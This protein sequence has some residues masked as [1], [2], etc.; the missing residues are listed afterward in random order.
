MATGVS[1]TPVRPAR[2]SG[3]RARTVARVVRSEAARGSAVLTGA[4]ATVGL[5]Y[6]VFVYDV[7]WCGT[8]LGLGV[9]LRSS[10]DIAGAVVVAGATWAAGRERR[11]GMGELFGSTSRPLWHRVVLEWAAVTLV[12]TVGLAAVWAAGAVLTGP[13][14]SYDGGRVW[15]PLVAVV[16]V[17][18]LAAVGIAIGRL[19]P[20]RGAA[21]VAAIGAYYV[22]AIMA[23]GRYS[24]G[25]MWLSP[26]LPRWW[27]PTPL[28]LHADGALLEILLFAAL[29]VALVTLVGARRRV[30]AVAPAA[31]AIVVAL[32]LAHGPGQDAWPLSAA[33]SREVCRGD[34]PKV[35]T[36]QISAFLL[37]DFTAQVDAIWPRLDGIAGAPTVFRE[38]PQSG[39]CLLI[40]L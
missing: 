34:V 32:P 8:W 33:A 12:A 2:P 4:V 9:A 30:W 11:R 10:L 28:D 23:S 6:G 39:S 18:M 27:R 26:T 20:W 19:V 40:S 38:V 29:T 5:V 31:L 3:R 14:A 13:I 22:L 7:T 25:L 21:P 36:S 37:D 35:C 1:S 24:D 17:G 16:S 15:H